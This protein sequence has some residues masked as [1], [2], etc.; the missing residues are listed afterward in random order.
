MG[1]KKWGPSAA[2]QG[3]SGADTSD[4]LSA[5]APLRPPGA[6]GGHKVQIAASGMP[7]RAEVT[8]ISVAWGKGPGGE[9]EVRDLG[10]SP[11]SPV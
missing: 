9:P 1:L 11:Q 3:L 10:P 4:R 5:A 2:L 8:G 7:G 6:H